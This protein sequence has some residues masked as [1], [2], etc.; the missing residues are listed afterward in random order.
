MRLIFKSR[1]QR[2]FV[3]VAGVVLTAGVL[4][5]ALF[6]AL[7]PLPGRDVT[8]ATGPPGS[9]YA[10][11]AE[12]YREILARDGVRLHLVPTKGAVENLERLRDSRSG[13]DAGFVQAGTTSERESPGLVSLGTLFYEPL[14]VFRREGAVAQLLLDLPNA[15]ISVG[16]QGSATRPLALKLLA[17]NHMD[18]SAQLRSYAPEEAARQLIAGNI[19]VAMILAGWDST[20]VQMLLHEPAVALMGLKRADAYVALFPKFSKLVVPQGVADLAMNRPAADVPMIASK[21]SLAVRRD[22]HSALQYLLVSAAL[23]VHAGPG[24]FQHDD[25]FPAP[26]AID[27]PIS[28]EAIHVYKAGPSILQRTLPFWLAELLQRLLV[29]VLP[30]VGILYPLWSL[31]PRIYRWQMQ[32]RI[33]RLYGELRLIERTL[34]QSKDPGERAQMLARFKELERQVLDLKMPQSF[35]EMSF[36]LK[37]HIRALS[38]SAHKQV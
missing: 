9:V 10:Q 7:R 14:W 20:A 17:L 5:S 12:R 8:I 22:M 31:L 36:N 21:A 3:G 27:L 18:A 2:T 35:G 29:I 4:L 24:I 25:E 37:M 30:I 6:V 38:E 16:E 13:V 23:E 26:Q 33:F 19:D 34:L 32:R 15:T 11:V 28:T 1:F